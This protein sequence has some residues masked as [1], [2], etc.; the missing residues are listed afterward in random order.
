M[1]VQMICVATVPY[2]VPAHITSSSYFVHSVRF[3]LRHEV[4]LHFTVKNELLNLLQ[5]SERGKATCDS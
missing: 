1:F 3:P 4:K 2:C 5:Q